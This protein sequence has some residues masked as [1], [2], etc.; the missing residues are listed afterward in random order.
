MFLNS[1]SRPPITPAAVAGQGDTGRSMG[2]P[3]ITGNIA[4]RLAPQL[5]ALAARAGGGEA[6]PGVNPVQPIR[7]VM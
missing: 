4:Q 3:V 1:P 2:R 5:S 7:G 6:P